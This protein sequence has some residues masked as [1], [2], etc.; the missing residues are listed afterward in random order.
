[1]QLK[2]LYIQTCRRLPAYGCELFEVK[3]V[4][5]TRTSRRRVTRILALGMSRILLLDAAT[6]ALIR[7]QATDDLSEWRTGAGS[8]ADRI[9]LEFRGCR[10]S[11]LA[12]SAA[13]M[14]SISNSLWTLMKSSTQSASVFLAQLLQVDARLFQLSDSPE[15][16]P[17]LSV[18]LSTNTSTKTDCIIGS[19]GAGQGDG[20]TGNVSFATFSGA[21]PMMMFSSVCSGRLAGAG[22]SSFSLPRI[23]YRSELELLQTMLHFPEEVALRLADVD[24]EIFY[25]VQ[26][27]DFLR[28]ITC[29]L[30]SAPTPTAFSNVI[31]QL[32][33]ETKTNT[34]AT[35]QDLIRRFNEVSKLTLLLKPQLLY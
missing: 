23:H 5:K 2:R 13:S 6:F 20:I 11:L 29:S 10:W 21:Y 32:Q 30:S 17:Q 22:G 18:G 27:V 25:S 9:L 8:S 28:H 33:P 1:M 31:N 14:Q 4:L 7:S 19:S 15:L 26:P 12:T 3:E 24:H 34:R 16:Q 35:V